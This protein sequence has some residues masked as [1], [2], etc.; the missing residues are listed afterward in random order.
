MEKERDRENSRV[1]A[2]GPKY[3]NEGLGVEQS[4]SSLLVARGRG[5]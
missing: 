5:R 3:A 2:V 1:I 4:L